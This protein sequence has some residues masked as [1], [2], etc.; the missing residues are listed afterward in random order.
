MTAYQLLARVFAQA[1]DGV[2]TASHIKLVVWPRLLAAEDIVCG[3][4]DELDAMAVAGG[5][6]VA[7]ADRIELVGEIHLRLA[8]VNGGHGGAV[9]DHVR[10]DGSQ[11][12]VKGG[13]VR[14]VPVW[15]IGDG[16]AVL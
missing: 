2:C 5:C 4:G 11:L 8:L 1:I 9:D 16:N 7:A 10:L 12:S 6:D 15:Q 3:D 13:G 14:D